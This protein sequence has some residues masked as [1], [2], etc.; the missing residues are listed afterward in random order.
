[1]QHLIKPNWYGHRGRPL[2]ALLAP[3]RRS[4]VRRCQCGNLDNRS[5]CNL[6]LRSSGDEDKDLHCYWLSWKEREWRKE[7]GEEEVL[8]EGLWWDKFF[9]YQHSM[10][11]CCPVADITIKVLGA[12]TLKYREDRKNCVASTIEEQWCRVSPP[13]PNP[14]CGPDT[15]AD[16]EMGLYHGGVSVVTILCRIYFVPSNV[17]HSFYTRFFFILSL[18][19]N[20]IF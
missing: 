8:Y 9:A 18:I 10:D 17:S 11:P 14:Q 15:Q 7:L 13:T 16:A 2:C 5:S 20:S 4:R 6:T 12:Y 19:Q 1:M 3:A